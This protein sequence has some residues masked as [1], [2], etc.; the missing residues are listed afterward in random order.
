MVLI[1]KKPK[2]AVKKADSVLEKL[3][4]NGVESHVWQLNRSKG[5]ANC[6]V[7]GCNKVVPIS[8]IE[9]LDDVDPLKENP[10][11]AGVI[12]REVQ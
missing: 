3:E 12:R 4:L 10:T 6:I 8:D 5:V 1:I 2:M 9:S 7:K 11:T